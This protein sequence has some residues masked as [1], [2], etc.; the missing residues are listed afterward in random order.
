[1]AS[2]WRYASAGALASLLAV[3]MSG[4]ASSGPSGQP[5][6]QSVPDAGVETRTAEGASPPQPIPPA[7]QADEGEGEALPERARASVDAPFVPDLLGAT[8]AAVQQPDLWERLRQQ[9]RFGEPPAERIEAELQRY[10]GRQSYFDIV[11]ERGEPYVR[12]IL[13]RI[14]ARDM[15]AEL[16]LVPLV[17]STFRPFAYSHSRAGGIWQFTPATGRHYGLD[18]NWWY[19]GRR[20]VVASTEAALDYLEYLHGLFDGDWLL[21]LAAYNAGEGRVRRAVHANERRGR[22]TEFWHLDL[23]R[24]TR[25]YVPR[26]LALRAI[27]AAPAE[28]GVELPAV[29]EGTGLAIVEL[30][31]QVDLA[32]AAE[33]AD[34]PVEDLYRYNP[35]FN[36]WATPPDG[37]HRLAL[38]SATTERF[39]AALAE[40]DADDMV[41][42][43][44]HQVASGET[45]SEI[46]G[47]YG[48][49][50]AA[51][52][53]LNDISGAFIR[54]GDHLLVPS[55]SRPSEA[56]A[57]S[58][59]NRRQA[60]QAQ[61]PDGRRRIEHH[62]RSGDTLWDVARKHDV[63]VR[64]LAAWN[65]MAPGDMLRPGDE[66]VVWVDSG[67]HGDARQAAGPRQR[68]Q[69][70]QYTV[71]SGDSLYEIAR[72]FGL[73]VA[74]IERWNDLDGND[75]L[76]PGQELEL[77]VDVTE[78][79]E[80]G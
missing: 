60:R 53:D 52:Q 70:V 23:P 10:S 63:G 55:A 57:L 65:D 30:P 19:D 68:L 71:R 27:L 7:A 44:R 39:R 61:G 31:G 26:I 76:Q 13:A 67:R 74:D 1:M 79:A 48:T 21:A 72:Q 49:S 38:P 36:R 41:R 58:A 8:P 20:D 32:L 37:P 2:G 50:V 59:S 64:T 9:F 29:N 40:R 46:A 6:Q 17:E 75:Y 69:R 78:Q 51:L 47:E 34:I 42:W 77:R 25:H 11:L 43:H 4:C 28:H 62:V 80:A 18:Q 16:I 24:Q 3:G 54:V 12:Y 15:P 45:L 73:R 22:P 14:E 33:L 66:L 56:Y 35:G 5:A